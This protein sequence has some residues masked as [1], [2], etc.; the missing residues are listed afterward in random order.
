MADVIDNYV[1]IS[2]N[3]TPEGVATITCSNCTGSVVTGGTYL[4]NFTLTNNSAN[5]DTLFAQLWSINGMTGGQ[6]ELDLY[7]QTVPGNT[8]V[9]LSIIL[10]GVNTD[11][12]KSIRV[13]HVIGAG[14]ENFLGYEHGMIPDTYLQ[15]AEN[16]VSFTDMPRS[17]QAYL[18]KTT[19]LGQTFNLKSK[20]VINNLQYNTTNDL[21]GG[22]FG[23]TAFTR[24]D[25]SKT[26]QTMRWM[27]T[28]DIGD[29]ISIYAYED[30]TP[31][32]IRQYAIYLRDNMRQLITEEVEYDG[33]IFYQGTAPAFPYTFYL[34]IYRSNGGA[35]FDAYIYSDEAMTNLLKHLFIRQCNTASFSYFL[36]V[37]SM[38]PGTGAE[39]NVA[40]AVISNNVFS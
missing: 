3:I 12:H 18:R 34:D 24:Q 28:S 6:K 29:G 39:A 5:S 35:D 22:F 2:I 38:G 13:G 19:T 20:L 4:V 40:A 27:S 23:L 16:Q 1:T 15:V 7:R 17:A 21:Q 9:P 26:Y 25:A 8:N 37:Y 11:V 30:T 32:G 31:T 14:Y 10:Q 36:P 33:W